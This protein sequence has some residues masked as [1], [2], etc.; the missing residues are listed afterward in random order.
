MR[1]F[2]IYL[3]IVS[4][5]FG[6]LFSTTDVYSKSAKKHSAKNHSSKKHNK[7]HRN[8]KKQ[9]TEQSLNLLK[10]YLPEYYTPSEQDEVQNIRITTASNEISDN[11]SIF[12]DRHLREKLISNINDWLGTRYSHGGHSKKGVDCSN[13]TSA[14]VE[15]TLGMNFPRSPGAQSALFQKIDDIKDMQ[16][17]DLIFFSG[18]SKKS[19]RIGHVGF[20]LGAGLFAHSSSG[21]G[22]IYTHISQ[23]Y[24]SVRFRHGARF[25][26]D[27][28][29][30]IHKLA[31]KL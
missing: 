24:Y 9:T 11:N 29:E 17:G 10:Q 4:V 8:G 21:R 30:S 23:D 12:S 2:Y 14:M 27:K 1:R 15:E 19:K 25:T 16:F 13:F 6:M 26:T 18:R 28:W 20:Y 3:L 7:K 22:V 31:N 5:S